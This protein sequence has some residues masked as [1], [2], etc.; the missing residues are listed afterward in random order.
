MNLPL[1]P[2]DESNGHG[3]QERLAL[4]DEFQLEP[5]YLCNSQELQHIC[6][7]DRRGGLR[8]FQ[9]EVDSESYQERVNHSNW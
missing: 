8:E 5:H 1:Y 7:Q 3:K 4:P 6:V 9:F 2:W